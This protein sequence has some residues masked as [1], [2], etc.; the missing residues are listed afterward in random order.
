MRQKEKNDPDSGIRTMTAINRMAR[1]EITGKGM[2][3]KR[4]TEKDMISTTPTNACRSEAAC[5]R[6]EKR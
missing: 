2:D 3:M 1:V 5:P 6:Q 4:V